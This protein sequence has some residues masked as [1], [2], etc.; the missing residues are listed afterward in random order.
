MARFPTLGPGDKVRDKHLPDRLTADQLDERVGTV[1]DS[2]YVPFER[3]AKNPD[4]LISGAITRNANQAVTSA[5]VV[6]PDGTPGTF[7]AET[8]STAFPGAVDGYR[9]TYGSPATKTYTQ[10]TITR[11]AAGAATAVPA[12][13]VS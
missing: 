12:I 2:R 3:L 8:L 11:N 5:A 4:L 13:V 9:I 6:W 10:P 7:T 1:G